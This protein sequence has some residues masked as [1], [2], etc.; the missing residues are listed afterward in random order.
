MEMAASEAVLKM[1][2]ER[3]AGALT[4]L[5]FSAQPEPLLSLKPPNASNAKCQRWAE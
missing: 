1:M 5:L 3:A 4:L 2:A